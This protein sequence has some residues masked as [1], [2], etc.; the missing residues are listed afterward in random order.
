MA[1][2]RI[3]DEPKTLEQKCFGVVHAE[4]FLWLLFFIISMDIVSSA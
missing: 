1:I 2:T 3:K 4:R